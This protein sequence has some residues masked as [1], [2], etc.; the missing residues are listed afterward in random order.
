[1]PLVCQLIYDVPKETTG[2]QMLVAPYVDASVVVAL[3]PLP[4]PVPTAPRL[5]PTPTGTVA[6][7]SRIGAV[8]VDGSRSTAIGKGA[9]AQQGGVDHWL[10]A[11]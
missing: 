1:M 8:C 5:A 4:A 3:G 6:S 9:C 7:G 10:F 11:P 2:L